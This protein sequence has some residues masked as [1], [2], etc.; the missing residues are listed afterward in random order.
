[1]IVLNDREQD[2]TDV[3][4]IY[5]TFFEKIMKDST[6]EIICTGLRANDMALRIYYGGYKRSFKCCRYFGYCRKSR[7]SYKAYDICD[8]DIYSITSYA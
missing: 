6:K 3:S 4:W 2:G 8:C 7:I 5:D 1:M